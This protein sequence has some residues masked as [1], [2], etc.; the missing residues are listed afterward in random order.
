MK[1]EWFTNEKE[2]IAT[3]YETNI[4]FNTVAARYFENAYSTII[5]FDL[6]EKCLLIKP[7]S[8]EEVNIRNLSLDDLHTMSIKKSYGRINGKG[9]IKKLC[10]Y[11][12]IDFSVSNAHKYVCEWNYEE[13]LLKIDL[14]KEVL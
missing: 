7:V 8:K 11:F 3:I 5:G 4:T 13:K 12:P 9:I 6:E 10:Y 14:N 2:K 1:I